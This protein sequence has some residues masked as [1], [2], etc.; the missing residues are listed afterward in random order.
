M[1]I[2]E[3]NQRGT[4]SRTALVEDRVDVVE[5]SVHH[6][7]GDKFYQFFQLLILK[8]DSFNTFCK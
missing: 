7:Q 3:N 5:D 2:L 6:L 4:E 8:S 1:E